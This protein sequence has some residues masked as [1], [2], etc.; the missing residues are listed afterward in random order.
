LNEIKVKYSNLFDEK[1]DIENKAQV[2]LQKKEELNKKVRILEE[3]LE[4]ATS[5]NLNAHQDS[6]HNTLANLLKEN[7]LLKR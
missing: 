7:E 1:R 2:D 6:L 3:R 5:K 4:Y